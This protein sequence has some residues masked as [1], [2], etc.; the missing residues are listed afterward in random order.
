MGR[1]HKK[2][3]VVKGRGII[4]RSQLD[5]INADLAENFN[6][7]TCE[8]VRTAAAVRI[9][10]PAALVN[11]VYSLLINASTRRSLTDAAKKIVVSQIEILENIGDQLLPIVEIAI[12]EK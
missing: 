5:A 12:Q 4:S 7:I 9:D 3:P 2:I 11:A 8:M 1:P 10:T 6:E